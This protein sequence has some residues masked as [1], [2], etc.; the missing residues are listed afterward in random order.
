MYEDIKGKF[1]SYLELFNEIKQLRFFGGFSLISST[2]LRMRKIR[3]LS[4]KMW[5]K[6]RTKM[7]FL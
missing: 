2:S 6:T 3:C 4:G 7:H 1:D 5:Q